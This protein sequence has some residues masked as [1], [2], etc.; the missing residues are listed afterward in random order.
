MD[1]RKERGRGLGLMYGGGQVVEPETESSEREGRRRRSGERKINQMVQ[2]SVRMM[3]DDYD[4]FRKI[5]DEERRTNGDMLSIMTKVYLEWRK[6]QA[7]K[8]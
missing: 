7:N 5:C 3:E 2:M 1:D 8:R 6:E 4:A